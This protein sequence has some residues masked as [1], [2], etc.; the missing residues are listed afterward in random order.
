MSDVSVKQKVIALL[1]EASAKLL[2]AHTTAQKANPMIQD[3]PVFQAMVKHQKEIGELMQQVNKL[4]G[5]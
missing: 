3:V 4:R 5:L 2:E 1:N